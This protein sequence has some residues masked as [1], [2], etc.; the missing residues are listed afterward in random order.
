MDLQRDRNLRAQ[1]GGQPALLIARFEDVALKIQIYGQKP[2]MHPL[3][4]ELAVD[5]FASRQADEAGI[6]R[7]TKDLKGPGKALQRD[8]AHKKRAALGH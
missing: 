8:A 6:W 4:P 1:R 2:K 5:L 3:D 7:P